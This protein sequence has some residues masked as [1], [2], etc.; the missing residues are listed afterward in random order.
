MIKIFLDSNI[1]LR[2][3]LKDNLEHFN[4]A[5]QILTLIK[6]GS[7]QPY[8]SSIVF[9]EVN[10]VLRSF[11]KLSMIQTL[12]YLDSMK[13]LRNITI[14]ETTHLEKSLEFYKNYK[15]KFTDCLIASQLR[16]DIILLSFDEELRKIKEIN[17]QSPAEFL[18]TLKLN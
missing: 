8:T 11:Y 3:F 17:S 9:L 6:E 13:T 5:A 2:V 10:Y 18:K 4:Q 12:I 16:K 14:F 7:I 1:F 15:I